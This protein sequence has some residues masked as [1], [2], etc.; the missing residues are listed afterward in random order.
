MS[1]RL[2]EDPGKCATE[3]EVLNFRGGDMGNGRAVGFPSAVVL[4]EL[5]EIEIEDV[6]VEE[7]E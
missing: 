5:E 3:F 1:I 4:L 2:P 6:E 7:V